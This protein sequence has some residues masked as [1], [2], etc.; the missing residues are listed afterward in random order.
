MTLSVDSLRSLDRTRDGGSLSALFVDDKGVHHELLFPI[1]LRDM[2]SGDFERIGY[3]LPILTT[4]HPTEY[5]SPVTGE[6]H[7]THDPQSVAATWEQAQH[8]LDCLD[9]MVDQGAADQ[10]A[11]F[12]VMRQ[13]V[14]SKGRSIA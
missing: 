9:V 8:I 13:I 11:L 4:F 12:D 10:R 5:R 14:S 6:V 1:H 2:P 7:V 3:K